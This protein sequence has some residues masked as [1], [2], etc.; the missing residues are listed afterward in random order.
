MFESIRGK[1]ALV[2]G[3]SGGIG[4]AIARIFAEHGARVGIHYYRDRA[5]AE[6][7]RKALRRKGCQVH[8]FQ[9]DLSVPGSSRRLMAEFIRRFGGIDC[10]INNAGAIS[11]TGSLTRLSDEDW[12]WTLALNARAPFFLAQAAIPHMRRQGSG[13]IINVSSV[14]AK[15]GGSPDRLHYAAAKAALEAVTVGLARSCAPHGIRVNAIRGG[16]IQTPFHEKIE[17]SAIRERIRKI[18]LRRPGHPLDIARMALF[19]A[20]ESGDFITGE[21]MTVAGG[22]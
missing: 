4:S 11:G 12:N 13:R 15:Y 18:P 2:T 20:S 8:C 1:R 9:A 14:A 7:L 6:S 10:L 16:F 19:L 22:D 3:G 21:V 5:S 17:R